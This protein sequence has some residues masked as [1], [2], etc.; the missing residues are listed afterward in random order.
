MHVVD[1]LIGR[2][3]RVGGFVA[4]ALTVPVQDERRRFEVE[5]ICK[6]LAELVHADRRRRGEFRHLGRIG[7]I[8][9]PQ[10]NH[11][12]SRDGIPRRRDVDEKHARAAGLGVQQLLEW[13]RHEVTAVNRD[14]RG[15]AAVDQVLGRAVAEVPRVFHV[16][17]NRVRAAQLVADVLGGDRGLDGVR[18]QPR[19]HLRF[20]DLAEIHFGDPQIPVVVAFHFGQPG[21]VLGGD[22]QHEPFGEN[23]HTVAPPVAQTFHDRADQRVDHRAQANRRRR[24]LRDQRERGAR[25]LPDP[26]RQVACLPPHRHDE[27]PAR[28]RFRVDHEVFHDLA[29][30]VP[31]GLITERVDVRRQVEIVVDGLRDVHHANASARALLEPH[32]GERRIVP[33]DGDELRHVEPQPRRDGGVEPLGIDGRVGPQDA[34]VRAAT[35]M[36]PAHRV[37]G[38]RDDMIDVAAHQPVE[39]VTDADD[40]EAL[41]AGPDGG[42]AD[43]A[44]NSRSGT[45]ADEDDEPPVTFHEQNYS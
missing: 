41:D 18:T 37:D 16:E 40:V 9:P 39:A 33:A 2:R 27:V 1:E 17:R 26:K 21:Q 11:V 25:R 23:R 7:E 43:D 12:P 10:A 6:V 35:K 36:N 29:A 28:R 44:V 3:R 15:V 20:E 34:K 24:L 5:E 22:A 4:R 45:A 38:E 32:C 8:I 13:N 31:G 19:H 30:V 42:G 14:H